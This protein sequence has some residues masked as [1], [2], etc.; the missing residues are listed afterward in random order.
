M[1]PLE[2]YAIVTRSCS[3]RSFDPAISSK[4]INKVRRMLCLVIYASE[5]WFIPNSLHLRRNPSQCLFAALPK[6]LAQGFPP[7]HVAHDPRQYSTIRYNDVWV[8]KGAS[9]MRNRTPLR[10]WC[11]TSLAV[12]HPPCG[13]S[14]SHRFAIHLDSLASSRDSTIPSIQLALEEP[15][16]TIFFATEVSGT[17]VLGSKTTKTRAW[18]GW[19]RPKHGETE[20]CLPFKP[21]RSPKSRRPNP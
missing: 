1:V 18:T 9:F 13:A 20:P 4:S 21:P 5:H 8:E 15:R 12:R 17:P 6:P 16:G 11:P 3:L 14:C 2:T 7:T 19:E 10:K